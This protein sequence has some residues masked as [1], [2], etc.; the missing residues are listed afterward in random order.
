MRPDFFRRAVDLVEEYRRPDQ[1]VQHT[2]QTNGMLIDDDWCAFFKSHNF[3]VGLSVDGPRELH[4]AY[5][6]DGQ[7]AQDTSV[8]RQ[9]FVGGSFSLLG[10]VSGG[11]IDR[12]NFETLNTVSTQLQDIVRALRTARCMRGPTVDAAPCD[13][14]QG[15]LIHISLS[16]MPES[17]DKAA[18]LA[19]PTGLT[20]TCTMSICSCRLGRPQ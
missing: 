15:E 12:Y 7:G 2:F 6:V 4:D 5:S 17:P 18:L 11:Q 19:I 8:A 14:V 9:K 1:E 10:L 16:T 20:I 3:L 13:D